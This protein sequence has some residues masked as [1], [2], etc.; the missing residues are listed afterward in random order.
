MNERTSDAYIENGI[1]MYRDW[2]MED[3]KKSPE[4]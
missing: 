4:L 3:R 2:E 1:N